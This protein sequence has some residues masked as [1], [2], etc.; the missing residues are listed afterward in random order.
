M[1]DAETQAYIATCVSTEHAKL[2][3]TTTQLSTDISNMRQEFH[4]MIETTRRQQTVQIKTYISEAV[5]DTTSHMTASATAPY[6]TKSELND[7]FSTLR[8]RDVRELL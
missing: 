5:R 6:A 8:K 2:M 7:M 1:T 4:T 3:N